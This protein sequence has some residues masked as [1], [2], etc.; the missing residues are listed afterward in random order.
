M[1]KEETNH[2]LSDEAFIKP[3]RAG[4]VLFLGWWTNGDLKRMVSSEKFGNS[5]PFPKPC[6]MHPLYLG[7]S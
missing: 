4:F 5:C 2:D 6:P 3:K 7:I 1:A